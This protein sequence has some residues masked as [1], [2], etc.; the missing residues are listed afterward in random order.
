MII[1]FEWP[2]V[3]KKALEALEALEAL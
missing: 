1:N 3:I 2:K